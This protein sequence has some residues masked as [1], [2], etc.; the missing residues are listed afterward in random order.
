MAAE[1]AVSRMMVSVESKSRASPRETVAA[2][3]AGED[4][5]TAPDAPDVDRTRTGGLKSVSDTHCRRQARR[6]SGMCA[7]FW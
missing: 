5:V 3:G 7:A 2:P 1:R 6:S 4:S